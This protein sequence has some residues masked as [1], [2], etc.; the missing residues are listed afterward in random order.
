MKKAEE[1]R[2]NQVHKADEEL[3]REPTPASRV[4]LVALFEMWSAGAQ[5]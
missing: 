5:V 2:I 4:S 3:D 1:S